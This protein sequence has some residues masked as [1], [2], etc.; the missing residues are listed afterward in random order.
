MEK[1]AGMLGDRVILLWCKMV[2]EASLRR[3]CISQDLEPSWRDPDLLKSV[4]L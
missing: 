1:S 3:C 2:L 4:P